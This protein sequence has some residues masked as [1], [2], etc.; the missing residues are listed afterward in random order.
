MVALTP[1]VPIGIVLLVLTTIRIFTMKAERMRLSYQ[2]DSKKQLFAEQI[3][4]FSQLVAFPLALGIFL[5]VQLIWGYIQA[6]NDNALGVY[7]TDVVV[8]ML[9]PFFISILFLV[10]NRYF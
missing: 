8:I 3:G 10:A 4:L 1:P 5:C 7:G 6:F 9:V 2:D